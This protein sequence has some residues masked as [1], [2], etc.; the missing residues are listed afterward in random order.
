MKFVVATAA[1]LTL[2]GGDG[3]PALRSSPLALSVEPSS[4]RYRERALIRVEVASADALAAERFDLYLVSLL[5]P[6]ARY[7]TPAGSWSR[8]PVPLGRGLG[9]AGFVAPVVA[10][11]EAGPPGWLLLGLVAVREGTHPLARDGWLFQPAQAWVMVRAARASPT[12]AEWLTLI[13]VT[14]LTA[15]L[16]VVLV[17]YP[18][19]SSARSAEP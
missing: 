6:T 12:G 1:L 7:L 15:I 14:L 16:A 19:R 9:G 11:P 4:V 8:D 3:R 5:S 13:G 17:R 18:A 2:F 10:W